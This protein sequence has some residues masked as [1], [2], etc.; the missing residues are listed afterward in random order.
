M[1]LNP[2]LVAIIGGR[3]SGK[4]ALVDIIALGCDAI[5]E[6]LSPASFLLRAKE[7]LQET[8]VSL[9]WQTGESSERGL[10]RPYEISAEHYPRARYLSQTFV[11]ELC[12]AQGMTDTLMREIERVIFEAHPLSDRDGAISF[13]ELLEMRTTRHRE[14][15]SR[16]EATLSELSDRIGTE[17]EKD[18]LVEGLK[19]QVLEKEKLITAYTKDRS[20]LVSKDSEARVKRLGALTE[21]SG[22]SARISP[23]L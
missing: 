4:T 20:K 22:E 3:G 14:A 1:A 11:E 13:E 21:G 8:S 7:L 23:L 17:L 2:G 9:G 15:R 12:S 6:H 16:S 10:R 19:K 18:K 5:S